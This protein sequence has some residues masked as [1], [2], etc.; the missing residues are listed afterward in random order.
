M[1]KRSGADSIFCGRRYRKIQKLLS[2]SSTDNTG[3]WLWLLPGKHS[4]IGIDQLTDTSTNEIKSFIN[5]YCWAFVSSGVVA[6]FISKCA[7]LQDKVIAPLFLSV[8]LSTVAC[9]VFLCNHAL[10][11]EPVTQNP[12]KLIYR[13]VKYAMGHRFPRLRSAFTYCEDDIPSRIDLGKAKYGGPF[14]T[15]QVEDVKT[16]FRVLGLALVVS[17]LFGMASE[18]DFYLIVVGKGIAE[19]ANVLTLFC[20]LTPLTLL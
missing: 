1:D 3:H 5:W 18:G 11:K 12:F 17:A 6:N 9:L 13:V 2:V 14:T 10:I 19:Q 4:S 7:S 15:E 16:F 20:S 8:A